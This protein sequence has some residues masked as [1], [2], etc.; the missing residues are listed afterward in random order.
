M[1]IRP[2][3]NFHPRSDPHQVN[4]GGGDRLNP[5]AGFHTA[6]WMGRYLAATPNVLANVSPIARPPLTRPDLPDAGPST[7]DAGDAVDAGDAGDAGSDGGSGPP[8]DRNREGC[9]CSVGGTIEQGIA[10]LLLLLG[11]FLLSHLATRAK[12][13]R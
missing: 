11:F 7:P 4:G 13:K 8:E 12:T 9:N 6:Y 3:S 10:P 2:P 5:G 1:R